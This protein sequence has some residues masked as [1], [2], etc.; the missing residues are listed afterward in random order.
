MSDDGPTALYRYRALDDD[1][2]IYV[3]I[4]GNPEGRRQNHHNGSPWYPFCGPPE[5]EWFPT[6]SAA[7]DAERC[8]VRTAEP[9]FNTRKGYRP[10][11]A[12]LRARNLW[13]STQIRNALRE[14]YYLTR[15][16]A[17]LDPL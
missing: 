12:D 4:T 14:H 17:R 15:A 13:L 11:A 3:G 16:Q 2:L 9:L 10:M 8:E 1:R 7:S 6:K 5:V